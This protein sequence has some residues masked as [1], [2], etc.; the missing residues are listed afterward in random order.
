VSRADASVRPAPDVWSVL[1]YGAHVRDV[2]RVFGAR[3]SMMRGTDNPQFPN[4]DQDETALAERYWEQDPTTVSAELD[5]ESA[6]IAADFAS[7][8]DGEWDRP[9]T[10]SNGSTFTVE[11]LGKYFLHD[12]EHHAHDIG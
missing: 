8:T 7:V 3:L 5:Q 11:T 2:C 12:L 1:E 10:R 9:G 6:R 4:W